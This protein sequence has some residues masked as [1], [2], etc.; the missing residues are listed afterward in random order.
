MNNIL[1]TSAGR[2]VELV[3]IFKSTLKNYFPNAKVFACDCSPELSPACFASDQSLPISRVYS[4]NY[5]QDLIRICLSNEIKLII[6]TID[7]ELEI[8]AKNRSQLIENGITPIVSD[9]SIITLCSD[10]RR[11][12]ELFSKFNIPYPKIYT[13]ENIVFPAFFKPYDGSGSHGA[14]VLFSSRDMNSKILS[15]KKNIFMELIPDSYVEYTV[16]AYF[17]KNNDLICLT[18][19]ERLEVRSG[20]VSKGIT[21]KDFVYNYLLENISHLPGAIGCLTIQLFVEK[22]LQIIIGLEINPRFGGGYP[23]AFEAGANF[24]DYLIK[25][26]LL[27]K[28]INF[29]DNW[30]DQLLML[31]YD[32]QILVK[33]YGK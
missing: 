10:K 33:N 17:N 11:T 29:F 18:P 19:R 21:R 31:R 22:K 4:K 9:H 30:E 25:E 6:P 28:K 23:L 16:D 5:I 1:I 32:S 8:L 24:A 7:T 2:R 13:K 12:K 15:N 14:G 20:E 27:N 3:N 26:Y